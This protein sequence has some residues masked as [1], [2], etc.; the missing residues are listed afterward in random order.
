MLFPISSLGLS[1]LISG[2][3]CF[4]MVLEWFLHGFSIINLLFWGF[5]R[6]SLWFTKAPMV[7]DLPSMREKNG[8]LR[9]GGTLRLRRR[10]ACAGQGHGGRGGSTTLGGG[11]SG[12]MGGFQWETHGKT[13]GKLRKTMGNHRETTGTPTYG[14][15]MIFFVGELH[16]DLSWQ[17]RR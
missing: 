2:D 4:L 5:P 7:I 13:M 11:V 12:S 3:Q 16:V 8:H 14:T 6:V 10:R 9:A 17:D 1:I 15:Y